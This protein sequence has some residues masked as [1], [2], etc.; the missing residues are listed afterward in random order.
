MQIK[1]KPLALAVIVSSLPLTAMANLSLNHAGYTQTTG[2][3]INE[4]SVHS[5]SFN[6]AGNNLLI[7]SDE[8]LRFGYL[9]NLGISIEIGEAENLDTKLDQVQEI[10][11]H[12]RFDDYHKLE[13]IINELEEAG[14]L[15]INAQV[16]APLT[17]FLFRSSL[18][19]GTFS[20]NASAGLQVS[21]GVIGAPVN[22]GLEI[23]TDTSSLDIDLDVNQFMGAYQEIESLWQQGNNFNDIN[24]LLSILDKHG[25]ID[26]ANK[27]KD[28]PAFND[29][30]DIDFNS[31]KALVKLW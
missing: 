23:P 15:R 24:S 30:K 1:L 3:V 29:I 12:K 6:P 2:G 19:Q 7:D 28:D 18:A 27:I 26:L 10:I 25:L 16:Q 4:G 31:G 5:S 17:P 9:S 20:L 11:K 8:K 22:L 13:A 14:Q 21:A